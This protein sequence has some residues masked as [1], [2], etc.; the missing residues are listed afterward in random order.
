MRELEKKFLRTADDAE[1]AGEVETCFRGNAHV[2]DTLPQAGPE[3]F[4]P[5]L[6]VIIDACSGE[7]VREFV[8]KV[9][10]REKL[11]KHVKFTVDFYSTD[12]N[13]ARVGKA[14]ALDAESL[15]D[16][17]VG[18]NREFITGCRDF[19]AKPGLSRD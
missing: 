8:G 9:T 1:K 7:F 10:S 5:L 2:Y 4:V 14:F 19:I 3:F 16:E 11:I 15:E 6:L 13:M 18:G 12:G 17:G